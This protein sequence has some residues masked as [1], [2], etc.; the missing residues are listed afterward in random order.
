M[1]VL[2]RHVPGR[3]CEILVQ[4][5]DREAIFAALRRLN[6]EARQ[7]KRMQVRKIEVP[8]QKGVLGA[9]I[10]EAG[11]PYPDGTP[12]TEYARLMVRRRT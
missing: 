1:I 9:W 3:K 8:G 12:P 4:S 11:P 5:D 6:A 2:E 7:T 10:H